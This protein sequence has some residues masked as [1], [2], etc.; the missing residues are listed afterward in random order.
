M[1]GIMK[2]VGS[3]FGGKSLL[4]LKDIKGFKGFLKSFSLSNTLATVVIIQ[5][6]EISSNASSLRNIN[7]NYNRVNL[8]NIGNGVYI[9]NIRNSA[10]AFGGMGNINHYIYDKRTNQYLGSYKN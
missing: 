5:G 9:I 2:K 3:F 1:G 7:Y 6:S 8:G 4:S 10:P